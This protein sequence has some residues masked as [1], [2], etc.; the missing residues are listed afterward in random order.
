MTSHA[1]DPLAAATEAFVL[2]RIPYGEADLVVHFATREIGRVACFARAAKRSRRRFP[3]GFPLFAL[4]DVRV[5]PRRRADSLRP[6][7]EAAVLR[8]HA[9]IAE[10]LARFAAA[11]L[12]VEIAREVLP[13]EQPEPEAFDAVAGYLDELD[14][15]AFGWGGLLAAEMR[16]LAPVGLA[17]RLARCLSC[18]APAPPRRAAFFDARRGGV[19]CRRCGGAGRTVSGAARA[20]MLSAVEPGCGPGEGGGRADEGAGGGAGALREAHRAML[21]FLEHHLGRRLRSAALLEETA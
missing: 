15:G 8:P 18:D 14:S 13:E 12:L 17:P 5:G 4:L 10:G 11:S 7:L 20:L 9:A 16:L 21:A 19:V 1:P 6:V 3:S 2:R